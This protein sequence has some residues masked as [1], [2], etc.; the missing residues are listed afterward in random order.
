MPAFRTAVEQG[1]DWIE[2]DV[3]RTRDGALV[4]LHDETLLRT[5]GDPR[6]VREVDAAEVVQLDAGS[7]FSPEYAGTPIPRLEEVLAFASETGVRLN[8]ELKPSG[9]ARPLAKA[10]AELVQAYGLEEQ[11][12]LASPS[13][14]VLEAVRAYAPE[15]R[16]LYVMAVAYGDLLRLDAA[17]AFSVRDVNV[18]AN[19]VNR[20]HNGQK[21]LW[22]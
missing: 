3:R 16:T 20:L 5:T 2:L 1:A 10:A 6:K 17:D 19:L 14:E 13:Y 7:W 11:C 18:T 12:V 8:I 4:V 22:V 9:D 21:T 15:L